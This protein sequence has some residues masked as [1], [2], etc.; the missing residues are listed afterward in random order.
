M[1]GQEAIDTQPAQVPS[2]RPPPRT[3]ATRSEAHARKHCCSEEH[4]RMRGIHYTKVGPK[5]RV[6]ES[7]T[8]VSNAILTHRDHQ[9]QP[10]KCE[11]PEHQGMACAAPPS[12]TSSAAAREPPRAI[13]I[14]GLCSVY[15]F[16]YLFPRPIP[17]PNQSRPPVPQ[18]AIRPRDKGA[19]RKE[20]PGP[21]PHAS[22]QTTDARGDRHRQALAPAAGRPAPGAHE[23]AHNQRFSSSCSGSEVFRSLQQENLQP[24]TR[25]GFFLNPSH[26]TTGAKSSARSSSSNS[27]PSLLCSAPPSR[28]EAARSALRACRSR[29]RSSTVPAHTSL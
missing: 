13:A 22:E 14:T 11:A 9:H 16:V 1:F 18:L 4:R 26:Y 15:L 20:W 8:P 10:Q 7:L 25:G 27:G 28:I 12:L 6:I 3:P 24:T 29:M 23:G 2:P 19:S 21:R 5:S 17:P